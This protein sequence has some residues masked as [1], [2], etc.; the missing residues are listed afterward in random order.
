MLGNT[1]TDPGAIS[2]SHTQENGM[3]CGLQIYCPDERNMFL[4]KVRSDLSELLS[5]PNL[6]ENLLCPNRLGGNVI[7]YESTRVAIHE[8]MARI[9]DMVENCEMSLQCMVPTSVRME[10]F[11]KYDQEFNFQDEFF[12]DFPNAASVIKCFDTFQFKK[13]LEDTTVE[14]YKALHHL[15]LNDSDNRQAH[16]RSNFAQ[17]LTPDEIGTYILL[18]EKMLIN[19]GIGTYGGNHLKQMQKQKLNLASRL[20]NFSFPEDDITECSP[21][22]FAATKLR[23]TVPAGQYL[24]RP[25]LDRV[26]DSPIV[27]RGTRLEPHVIAEAAEMKRYVSLPLLY[28]Q[29]LENIRCKLIGVSSPGENAYYTMFDEVDYHYI[30]FDITNEERDSL[31]KW[32][33]EEL[34]SVYDFFWSDLLNSLQKKLGLEPIAIHPQTSS[35]LDELLDGVEIGNGNHISWKTTV[36]NIYTV[37]VAGKKTPFLEIGERFVRRFKNLTP[38]AS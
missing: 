23:F 31:I 20:D 6:L 3:I 21:E 35:M 5:L 13:Y 1:T 32:L 12:A 9:V 24:G 14:N 34:W 36:A 25:M 16:R 17:S 7:P 29:S 28:A 4:S 8:L 19:L 15:I 10:F 2:F 11:V 26:H 33:V 38:P 22:R 27:I 30:A 18:A 37:N